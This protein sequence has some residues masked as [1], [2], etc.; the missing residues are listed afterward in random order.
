[1]E[2]ELFSEDLTRVVFGVKIIGKQ[3]IRHVFAMLLALAETFHTV[4][5][6][7]VQCFRK[8]CLSSVRPLTGHL[9]IS[10]LSLSL[11]IS[12]HIQLFIDPYPS[13]LRCSECRAINS[14]LQWRSLSIEFNHFTVGVLIEREFMGRLSLRRAVPMANEI[15]RP[16]NVSR[17]VLH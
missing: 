10:T 9:F 3:C 13:S 7:A 2:K 1:M 12:C 16:L 11:S 15:V 14:G 17:S 8:S 5:R 4:V 6:F